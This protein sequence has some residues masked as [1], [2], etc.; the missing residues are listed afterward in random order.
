[1][2]MKSTISLIYPEKR[3]VT[4]TQIRQWCL[5]AID[6]GDV[7]PQD[8]DQESVQSMAEALEDAGLITLA[9]AQGRGF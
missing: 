9:K 4:E 2:K 7:D 8:V 6:N 5:D 1:M 3:E